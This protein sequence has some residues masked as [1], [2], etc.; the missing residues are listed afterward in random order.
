MPT[1]LFHNTFVRQ[2]GLEPTHPYGHKDLNLAR[3]PIPP[4]AQRGANGSGPHAGLSRN[5]RIR[6]VPKGQ[7]PT[8][9]G[10]DAATRTALRG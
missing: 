2:V 9:I 1:C 8:T 4:L 6:R 7:W 3:L 5:N 10:E